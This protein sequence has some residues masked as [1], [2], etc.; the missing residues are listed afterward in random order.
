MQDSTQHSEQYSRALLGWGG[1]S[2]GVWI[3]TGFVGLLYLIDETQPHMTCDT[4]T[5]FPYDSTGFLTFHLLNSLIE[6]IEWDYLACDMACES[7]F[8]NH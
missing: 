8:A 5:H 3:F 2:V 1:E 4:N 6:Q 7:C